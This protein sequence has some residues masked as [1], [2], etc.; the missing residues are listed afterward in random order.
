MNAK[1]SGVL[2]ILTIAM[3]FSLVKLQESSTKIENNEQTLR[4]DFS[5][6]DKNQDGYVDVHELRTAMPGIQEDD[7]SA[8]FDRYDADRDGVLSLDEYLTVTTSK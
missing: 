8:F 3:L 5:S 4:E 1:Q 7:L 6:L 2:A